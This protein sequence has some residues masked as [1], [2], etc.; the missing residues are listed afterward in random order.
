MNLSLD[1]DSL[2]S[3]HALWVCCI[4]VINSPSETAQGVCIMC[5]VDALNTSVAKL[6]VWGT[7]QAYTEYLVV[8]APTCR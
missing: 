3:C 1:V 5:T 6:V 8:G 2:W 7:S 4:W